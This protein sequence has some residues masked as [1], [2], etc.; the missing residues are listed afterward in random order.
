MKLL[1]SGFLALV[2]AFFSG[3]L[4]AATPNDSAAYGQHAATVQVPDSL[5]LPDIQQA[6]FIAATGRGWTVKERTEGRIVLFLE[7]RGWRSTLTLLYS[8]TEVNVYSDSGK[9]DSNGRIK[10]Q[11]IPASWVKF[12]KQDITKQ[13]SLKLYVK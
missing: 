4:G 11:E 2:L 8:A 12:L 9:T 10:K 13:L 6:I 7:Q 3:R 5:G 1:R